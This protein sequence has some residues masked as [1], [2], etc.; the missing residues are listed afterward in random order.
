MIEIL[1]TEQMQVLAATVA[2]PEPAPSTTSSANGQHDLRLDIPKWLSARGVSFKVKDRPDQQGRQV[3]LL[4]QCPF[5][6]SHGAANEVA[7]YQAPDGK[8]G[9]GCKHNSCIGRGWQ[10]FKEQIGKPDRD[11]FDPPPSV[12]N[13]N[14]SPR[15]DSRDDAL[16][17]WEPSIVSM[18]SIEPRAVKWLWKNR[19][20][21]GKLVSLSGNPGLGKTLVLID[22]ASRVTTGASWPDGCPGG[23]PGGVVIC[24]AEDD[25]HDTLRPRF[26]AAGADVSRINLVESVVQ[27]DAK[28]KRRSE[29]LIDL[30]RDLT[31]ISK[32]LDAT[33][34]CKLLI[35]DPINA[36][37]GK[38][39]SHKNAE[40]RQILGPVAEMCHRKG[41]AFIYLGHLNKTTNGPAMYRTA[42]SLA[43]VAAAR[44]AY[45]VAESKQDP[46]V[47]LFLPVKNNLAANIGGLSFQVVAENDL[48]RIAWSDIPVTM[49]A[50]EALATD[51]RE[52][53]GNLT[54]D[55]VWLA[56]TTRRRPA[57]LRR[58]DGTGQGRRYF[59]KSAVQRQESRW[60]IRPENRDR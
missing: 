29:R 24:S 23:E 13:R 60:R 20:P 59:Q 35:M 45:I 7:I 53:R 16:I 12:N 49:T 2:R 5:D 41:V 1:S 14:H 11:H 38:T 42:G 25:P 17:F 10:E 36:Y 46:N 39:D 40:V 27:M 54:Q 21:N 55:K 22:I 32:A 58:V 50:D 4:Q 18:S 43:F 37:L 8:I 52:S 44:V 34:N 33:P 9:A 51:T 26:D 56:G 47:R 57:G 3:F 48:P 19:I 31:A 15:Q 6:S 30:Q 28:T